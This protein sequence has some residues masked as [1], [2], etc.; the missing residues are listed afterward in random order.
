MNLKFRFAAPEDEPFLRRLFVSAREATFA[1][2]PLPQQ[3]LEA[4]IDMQYRARGSQYEASYPHAEQRLIVVDGVEVGG[5]LLNRTGEEWS[6]VDF[7]VLAEERNKGYG[8]AALEGII[9]EAGVVPI[10]LQ[11]EA[12]NP[13]KRLYDRLG[14]VLVGGDNFILEMRRVP[15]NL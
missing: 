2:L 1:H 15:P 12:E 7:G 10:R 4:L 8:T 13:A 14:F 6:I 9:R 11:V 5:L 3:Q